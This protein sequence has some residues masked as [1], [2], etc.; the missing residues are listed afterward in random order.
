MLIRRRRRSHFNRCKI[1][2]NGVSPSRRPASQCNMSARGQRGCQIRSNRSAE[3][4]LGAARPRSDGLSRDGALGSFL[5]L[6]A[7]VLNPATPSPMSSSS[8]VPVALDWV[9]ARRCGSGH[10]DRRGR[11]VGVIRC[12]RCDGVLCIQTFVGG[13]SARAE[14]GEGRRQ[15]RLGLK[16]GRQRNSSSR[17]GDRSLMSQSVHRLKAVAGNSSR[18]RRCAPRSDCLARVEGDPAAGQTPNRARCAGSDRP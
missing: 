9:D 3:S 7:S 14:Q 18:V 6:G 10:Q 1:C 5:G 2:V 8:V 11:R 16:G 4:A 17:S 15:Q 12:C 13:K